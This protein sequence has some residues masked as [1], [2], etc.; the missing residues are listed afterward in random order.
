MRK[1]NRLKKIRISEGV[2]ISEFSRLSSVSPP[3][4][5]KI[6][7]KKINCTLITKNKIVNGLNRHPT[8]KKEYNFK[9]I[10]PNE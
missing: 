2:S 8:K 9:D 7:S 4:I 1:K 3:T 5:R 6:E 10:F